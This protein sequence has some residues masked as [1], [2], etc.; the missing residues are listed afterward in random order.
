MIRMP[1]DTICVSFSESNIVDILF[2]WMFIRPSIVAWHLIG[3]SFI[4]KKQSD[5]S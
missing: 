4:F 5:L 2:P 1:I 3:L